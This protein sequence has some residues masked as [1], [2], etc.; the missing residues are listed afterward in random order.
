VGFLR[1]QA[2]TGGAEILGSPAILEIVIT[3]TK[4]V[5]CDT[6]SGCK[7]ARLALHPL[8]LAG[9]YDFRFPRSRVDLDLHLELINMHWMTAKNTR[10]SIAH[11]LPEHHRGDCPSSK[12]MRPNHG[13]REFEINLH[14]WS[15]VR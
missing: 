4:T 10:V 8:W 7:F 9:N 5:R 3:G 2:H 1:D 12:E 15:P 14:S 6:R 11:L 13:G